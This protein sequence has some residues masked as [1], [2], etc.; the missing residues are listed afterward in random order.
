MLRN[1]IDKINNYKES[2]NGYCYYVLPSI[3]LLNIDL[4]IEMCYINNKLNII[5]FNDD[6]KNH[7]DL[8]LLILKILNSNKFKKIEKML[9][10]YSIN[11]NTMRMSIIE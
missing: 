8:I 3:I 7:K 5:E 9:S 4:F 11:N 1:D 6:N 2:S 10:K